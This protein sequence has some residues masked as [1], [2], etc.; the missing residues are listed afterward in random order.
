MGVHSSV[1]LHVLG[2]RTSPPVCKLETLI[3]ADLAIVLEEVSVSMRR[4]AESP[5]RPPCIK[6]VHYID[7]EVPL[8]P[9]DIRVSSM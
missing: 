2:E 5:G 9:E 3:S 4:E 8:K 6:Q 1:E 7:A